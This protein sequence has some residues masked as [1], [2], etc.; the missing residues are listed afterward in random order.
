M[1]VLTNNAVLNAFINAVTTPDPPAMT[2]TAARAA[3][4]G[5]MVHPD[6][7][8]ALQVQRFG[9][10]DGTTEGFMPRPN[11][12]YVLYD[13]I[14]QRLA[15]AVAGLR[16]VERRRDQLK[17]ERDALRTERDVLRAELERLRDDAST[18]S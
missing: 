10:Q 3:V 17:M 2:V 12:R 16:V 13:E 15:F 5:R 9:F 6:E 7:V 1:T 8:A 18:Q 11:G 14:K 4:L